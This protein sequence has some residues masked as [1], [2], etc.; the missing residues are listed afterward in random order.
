MSGSLPLFR[1]DKSFILEKVSLRRLVTAAL[2]TV[3]ALGVLAIVISFRSEIVPIFHTA[4]AGLERATKVITQFFEELNAG[5]GDS[6]PF[7][8]DVRLGGRGLMSKIEVVTEL[9][10]LPSVHRKIYCR[11]SDGSLTLKTP[12]FAQNGFRAKIYCECD[13]RDNSGTVTTRRFPLE[14]EAGP[15]PHDKLLITGLW[16]PEEMVLWQRRPRD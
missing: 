3:I 1:R 16:H 6:S 14:I 13:L 11:M 4:S 9:R 5:L 2:A 12:E 15:N 7:A 8:A 10:N